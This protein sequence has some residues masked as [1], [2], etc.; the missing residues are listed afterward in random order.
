MSSRSLSNYPR[1][2]RKRLGFSQKELA[3][4]LG[5]K[6]GE[7]ISRYE[8]FTRMPTLETALALEIILQAPVKELFRGEFRKVE[9][10]IQGRAKRLAARLGSVAQEYAETGKLTRL[11][12]LISDGAQG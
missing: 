2:G 5:C 12:R 1:A 9:R 10:S 6:S 7:A 4:L 3:I 8:R 11:K